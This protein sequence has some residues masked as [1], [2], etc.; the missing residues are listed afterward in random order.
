MHQISVLSASQ[1]H[2]KSKCQCGN[3]LGAKEAE[4][5]DGT[6]GTACVVC[7][8]CKNSGSESSKHAQQPAGQDQRLRL[9]QG[10]VSIYASDII[11]RK[12]ESE[13]QVIDR[14]IPEEN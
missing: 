14:Y 6:I 9:E 12:E 4:G 7:S 10:I 13:N 5:G 11:H 8:M 1:S 2:I 3:V